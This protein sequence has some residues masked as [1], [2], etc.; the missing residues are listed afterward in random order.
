MKKQLLLTGALLFST[1]M[2]FGAG[3]QLNLQGLR[4]LAMGGSGTAIPWDAATMFYNPGG[5]SE[6]EHVTAYASGQFVMPHVKYVQSPTG[7]YSAETKNQTF[8]TF[9][10]YVGGPIVNKSPIS[11]GLAVYTPFG[12]GLKWDD[13]WTGR[14]IVQEI[15]LSTVFFQPTISWRLN[16]IVSIGGGFVYAAGSMD[17]KRAIPVQNQDGTNGQASLNGNARGVGFNLGIHLKA[18]E[19]VMIGFNYRSRVNMKVKRGYADFAVPS[20]QESSFPYTAF[21]STLPLPQ[22]GTL[23]VGFKASETITLQADV[24]YTGWSAYENLSFDYEQN[25]SLLLDTRSPR[26]YKNTL[27]IRGGAHLK[28]SEKVCAMLGAGWDPSPVRDGYL[29]P[30][31]PDADRAIF[32]GGFTYKPFEKF[33]VLGAFEYVSTAKREGSLEAENFKGKYQTKAFTPGI[34]V[35]LDF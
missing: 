31:L 34:G 27:S 29:A 17:M 21:T 4:Q 11:I 7:V 26:H 30:E 10:V 23:G 6:F 24:S 12:T 18:S 8:T 16:E 35:T 15:K 32:T 28:L 19:K 1:A 22:V 5:L 2:S 13:N 33:T 9:N 14:F 3:Y 20:S 25:T